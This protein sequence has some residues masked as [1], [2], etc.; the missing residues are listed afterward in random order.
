MKV[1]KITL[2]VSI[3]IF[4][5]FLVLSITLNI[6][7]AHPAVFLIVD[8]CVG[9]GCSTLVVIITTLIQ[10]MVEQKKIINKLGYIIRQILHLYI[11]KEDFFTEDIDE[12]IETIKYLKKIKNDWYEE[13][14]Y[15]IDEVCNYCKELQFF[16]TYKKKFNLHKCLLGVKIDL[17]NSYTN[18]LL[19]ETIDREF[20]ILLQDKLREVVKL[21]LEFR[22]SENDRNAILEHVKKFKAK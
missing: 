11:L 13:I 7:V 21:T 9:I 4:I 3:I 18:D 16:F 19:Y 1:Y 2:W 5:V 17:M 10:F 15:K 22:I 8:W 6:F 14:N 12:K 20:Y